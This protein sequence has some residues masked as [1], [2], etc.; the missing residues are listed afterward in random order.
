MNLLFAADVPSHPDFH[1]KFGGPL[2]LVPPEKA[3]L[4]LGMVAAL[5][6]LWIAVSYGY[7][8]VK[9]SWRRR[10]ALSAL[11]ILLL[12]TVLALVAGPT[13][14]QRDYVRRSARPM[15]V[16]LDRSQSMTKPDFRGQRRLDDALRRW[17]TLESA[18]AARHGPLKVFSFASDTREGAD[19]GNAE[20]GT[21]ETR[22]FRSL[23]GMLARAPAGGW[24]G[25]VTLTDGLDTTGSDT[26]E[27]VAVVARQALATGT[28]LYFVAGHNFGEKKEEK[29]FFA[30]RNLVVPA[31]A[32]P[33][34]TF[35]V[36]L[37]IESY[38]LTPRSLPVRVR[39]GEQWRDL[40]PI[41]LN[42][43][44][45]AVLWRTDLMVGEPGPVTVELQAGQGTDM[46]VAR[47][48][49]NVQDRHAT[50]RILHCQFVP[51]WGQRYLVDIL[52]RDPSLEVH[53]KS[54]LRLRDRMGFPR[55]A[56]ALAE[57][58]VII[59]AEYS[60]LD[61]GSNQ[62]AALAQWVRGGG[63][64]LLISPMR[65]D[66]ERLAESEI[67]KILPVVFAKYSRSTGP[68]QD[69]SEAPAASGSFVAAH[70]I[71]VPHGQHAI[72]GQAVA[73]RTLEVLPSEYRTALVRQVAAPDLSQF[74]WEP[75]AAELFPEGEAPIPIVSAFVGGLTAKPGAEVL[76]RHETEKGPDGKKA[77]LLTSQR[78]GAGVT[79]VLAS[80]SLW[81]WKLLQGSDRREPERFWGQLVQWLTRHQTT[82]LR[83]DQAPLYA[84]MGQS[85]TLRVLGAEKELETAVARRDGSP[86]LVLK[87]AASAE[88]GVVTFEW[89]PESAGM[90]HVQARTRGGT[91]AQHWVTVRAPAEVKIE[92]KSGELSGQPTDDAVLDSLAQ[93]TGGAILEQQA[94]AAWSTGEKEHTELVAV[95]EFALWHEWEL[96]LLLLGLYAA[97]LVLRRLSRL[98]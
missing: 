38:Q 21:G 34:S 37:T 41:F 73:R 13:W 46:L 35:P 47:T 65:R 86:E 56:A 17:R 48:G 10:L 44:R 72:K 74:E 52:R 64:L 51:D 68:K 45:K 3:W 15:A 75:R 7:T 26:K 28:P 42:A 61:L 70:N 93:L 27:A 20:L 95:R 96:L 89:K 50:K 30:W 69:Q 49:V 4:M 32:P 77:V 43:G 87:R 85:L 31:T 97:D 24:A 79:A 94:P 12:L 54:V 91:S 1:W 62:Q 25:I 88:K 23:E 80:D 84:E 78:Y 40:P 6:V 16:L 63:T 81:R 67:E 18:A 98:L 11:R 57:W 66:D 59:L 83:F 82:E 55:T 22:L 76:A 71:A 58:D 2:S 53:T 8:L 60:A 14:S 19:G 39:I 90:W 5:G 33:R 29:S 36:E 9:L 92:Q